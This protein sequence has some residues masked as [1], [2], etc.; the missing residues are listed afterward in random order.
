MLG[1]PNFANYEASAALLRIPRDGGE[2]EYVG[3]A[4]D[5]LS[6]RGTATTSRCEAST[7]AFATSGSRI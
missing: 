1:V 3:I 2:I 4:E 5:R 7:T 6:P